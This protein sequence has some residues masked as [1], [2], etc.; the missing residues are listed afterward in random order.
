MALIKAF[1][2]AIVLLF[3]KRKEDGQ[4]YLQVIKQNVVLGKSLTTTGLKAISFIGNIVKPHMIA[5]IQIEDH[6]PEINIGSCNRTCGKLGT[7][8]SLVGCV[9]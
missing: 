1:N 8:K 6:I 4:I 7:Y 9:K 3:G 2:I 5:H